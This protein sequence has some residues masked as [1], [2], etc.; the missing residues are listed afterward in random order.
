MRHASL[1][2]ELN[3]RYAAPYWAG[4]REGALRLPRCE[5]CGH[6][7]FPMGP[8]CANCLGETFRWD[9]MSGRGQV[10]SFVIYHHVFNPAFRDAVPYNV[11]V[12]KLEE[13]PKLI[14]NVVGIPNEALRNGMSVQSVFDRIDDELTL[15]RFQPEAAA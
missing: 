10:W 5:A 1:R 15:L 9:T 13:G 6:I 3:D 14:T 4:L 8:C 7:Q 2:P 11:A 12:V